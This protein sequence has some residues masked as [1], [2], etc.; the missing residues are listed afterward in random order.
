MYSSNISFTRAMSYSFKTKISHKYFTVTKFEPK[1]C[2]ISH[3]SSRW[4]PED[5][6]VE[7]TEV[8]DF[9]LLRNN[10]GQAKFFMLNC[11]GPGKCDFIFFDKFSPFCS[12]LEFSLYRHRSF[13]DVI[14]KLIK[15]KYMCD[16]FHSWR[17]KAFSFITWIQRI[18]S[19]QY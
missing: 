13:S 12:V 17:L 9:G 10:D 6:N 14:F 11:L 18:K 3:H 1:S 15:C 4:R 5:R 16:I 2:L 8:S 7:M 19:L